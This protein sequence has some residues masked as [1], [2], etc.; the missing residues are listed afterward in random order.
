MLAIEKM[1]LDIKYL[2]QL[3]QE[4]E[5]QLTVDYEIT[6]LFTFQEMEEFN[7]K[8]A[9]EDVF[10]QTVSNNQKFTSDL[11]KTK[12]FLLVLVH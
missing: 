2:I 4:K 6:S 11:Q 10:R 1:K 8:L 12:H 9:D 7:E 5:D 3:N